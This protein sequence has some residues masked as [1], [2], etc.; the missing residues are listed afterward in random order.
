MHFWNKLSTAALMRLTILASLDLLLGRLVGDWG[1]LLH[2]LFFLI[3]VTLN[4]GLYAVMVYTGTLN[5]TLIGMMSSG[6]AATLL[7]LA[8]T[9]ISPRTFLL[10]GGPFQVIWGP[11]QSLLNG[12]VTALP[13]SVYAGGPLSLSGYA[14]QFIGYALAGAAGLILIIAGG[15]IARAMNKEPRTPDTSTASPSS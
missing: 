7:T 1:I 3:I 2:P 9:G 5:L 4:L 13:A 11:L 10:H 14:L 6:L 8:Y 15:L 12:V